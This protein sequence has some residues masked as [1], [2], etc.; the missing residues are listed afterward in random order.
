MKNEFYF[1]TSAISDLCHDSE[2]L[3]LKNL[4][5]QNATV[6]IS[7]LTIA[8]LG[9]TLCF[10]HRTRLLNLAKDLS[11]GI[12][13]LA[14]PGELLKRAKHAI[15]TS[16]KELVSSVDSNHR[17]WYV[18]NHPEKMNDQDF[19]E[20]MAWK[21]KQEDWFQNMHDSGRVEIQKYINPKEDSRVLKSFARF[22]RSVLNDGG[23]LCE[24]VFQYLA[25]D[26]HTNEETSKN[27]IDR[28]IQDSE[29]WR[30]FIA[31]M[32]YG[33]HAR[34]LRVEGYSKKKNPG[35]I[36]TQ[37]SIYLANCDIF[38]SS[39]REHLRMLRL[40]APFGHDNRQIWSYRRF[41]DWL[42]SK[43]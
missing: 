17:S 37:Q 14:E 41:K 5:V 21:K 12:R 4:I 25:D 1:D 40:L 31:G 27:F 16:Q 23:D 15:R 22:I 38:V 6:Y 34:S 39:D 32:A 18:L 24:V 33:F 29:H 19:D 13:P 30:F 36:D 28:L 3:S 9:S 8:E 7:V 42:I 43:K 35:S 11:C 10:Y 2:L 26:I 20:I